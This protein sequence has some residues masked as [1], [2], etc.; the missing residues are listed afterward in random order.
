MIPSQTV[1]AWAER[2]TTAAYQVPINR[3]DGNQTSL[4]EYQGAAGRFAADTPPDYPAIVVAS[5]AKLVH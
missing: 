1:F 4:A 3:S 2:L 5:E